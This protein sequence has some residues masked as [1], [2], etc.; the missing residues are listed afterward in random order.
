MAL[1][2]FAP[3][4]ITV[5]LYALRL[6]AARR[7]FA[8]VSLRLV[9]CRSLATHPPTRSL[10]RLLADAVFLPHSFTALHRLRPFALRSALLLL[11]LLLPIILPLPSPPAG[12]LA[13]VEDL[14]AQGED[15]NSRGAQNRTPLHR[16]VGKGHNGVVRLLIQKGADLS[17]LDQGGLTPLYVLRPHSRVHP[18]P[19][20]GLTSNA[21]RRDANSTASTLWMERRAAKPC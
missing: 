17:L 11:L 6:I 13:S 10:A 18:T 19:E 1:F 3:H 7:F 16:A 8:I 15:V 21:L 12:D 14:L 9:A 5:T 2:V 20:W 4:V